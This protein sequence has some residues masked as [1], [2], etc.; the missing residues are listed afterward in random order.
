MR[1]KMLSLTIRIKRNDEFNGKKLHDLLIELFMTN[2]I[3][4]CTIWIGVD[5]FG[6]RK[7]SAISIEGVT[8]NMPMMIEVVDE[9]LNIEPILPEIKRI[10][11]DNGL[12][13][14]HEVDAI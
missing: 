3:S 7:R 5:G 12:I 13:T 6:K 10:V 14:I 2:N 8:I 9:R 4:G 1:T 11:G